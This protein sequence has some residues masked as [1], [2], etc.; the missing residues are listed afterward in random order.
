MIITKEMVQSPRNW[1]REKIIAAGEE[2]PQKKGWLKRLIGKELPDHVANKKTVTNETKKE[3]K[4]RKQSE[5]NKRTK[6]FKDNFYGNLVNVVTVPVKKHVKT[7][8]L[9]Y[10]KTDEF[11][12]SYEWRK[13]RLVVLNLHGRKC[14][15]C[16]ASPIT[17]AV[18]N[19]DHIKPRKHFP[20]LAL[21]INNLQVLCHECNHGKGNWD[22]T[23]F[24]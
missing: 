13:L 14:Q 5:K 15:C 8:N 7:C 12:Q 17:G 20:H 6:E 2:W 3:R 22:Q 18:M 23:D 21:D 11:L 24:R 9:E 16:G 19:V 10:V 4:T 1:T